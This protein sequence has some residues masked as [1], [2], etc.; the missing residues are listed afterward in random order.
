MPP[1]SHSSPDDEVED[2]FT[3]YWGG[4]FDQDA[5]AYAARMGISYQS[6]GGL[7][8]PTGIGYAVVS[9]LESSFDWRAFRAANRA[10]DDEERARHAADPNGDT[11]HSLVGPIWANS[12]RGEKMRTNHLHILK[13]QKQ[14]EEVEKRIKVLKN[15]L[16]TA[17]DEDGEKRKELEGFESDVGLLE[18]MLKLTQDL[19]DLVYDE[20]KDG[21]DWAEGLA[22]Q[23]AV[24]EEQNDVYQRFSKQFED[25]DLD[26]EP[27]LR[28]AMNLDWEDWEDE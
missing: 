15:E 12:T 21:W 28:E 26:E 2:R 9:D 27:L 7:V 20:T 13:Y 18:E 16:A 14:L 19:E 17:V 22:K 23:K 6:H 4:E 3:T 5:L 1:D 11:G 8:I 25:L 24:R 10:S